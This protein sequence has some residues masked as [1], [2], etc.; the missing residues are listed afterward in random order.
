MK[1]SAKPDFIVNRRDVEAN[2]VSADGDTAFSLSR[3]SAAAGLMHLDVMHF[4][5]PPGASAFPPIA[6]RDEEAFYFVLGGTPDLWA[7]GYLYSLR[8]GDGIAVPAKTGLAHT[9]LNNSKGDVRLL[10][11]TEGAHYG[12]RSFD[13][14]GQTDPDDAGKLW[15]DPPRRKLGPHDG[16]TDA[17]R[18]GPS[19]AGSRKRTRPDYV[20]HWRD[21][22]DKKAG[23]YPNSDED[24]GIDARFGRRAR[25]SRIGVHVEILKAGRRTSWPHAE[26]DEEEFVYVVSGALD[27]WNDGT[28]TALGE[29][30]FIG[31]E[32]GTG[33]THAILNNSDEDAL[34]LVGGE[35]SR[36]RA[37]IWYPLHPHRDKETGEAFW[38]DHPKPKLG[39]H[40]GMPDALRARV[41]KA[42]LRSA[43]AA[44]EAARYLGPR[45]TKT[46]K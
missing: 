29:G 36:Q 42:K 22:L 13:P 11:M 17:E 41:P 2:I 34:L 6:M 5:L 21:I 45:K 18:G 40:D 25:F 44:N 24:Q 7:D 20:A 35:A 16:L 30:D 28:I 46:R 3:L 37:Q 15:R 1:K 27:A 8:E 4:N 23:R 19:P 9:F 31:W 33:I 39:P 14:L 38:A 43:V 12:A 32:A 10:M 26:R